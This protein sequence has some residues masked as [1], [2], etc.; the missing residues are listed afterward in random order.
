MEGIKS[1]HSNVVYLQQG[2]E[3]DTD[4]GESV[5]S[6]FCGKQDEPQ[7]SSSSSSSSDECIGL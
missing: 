5:D 7:S 4:D 3:H 1:N 2:E 6:D